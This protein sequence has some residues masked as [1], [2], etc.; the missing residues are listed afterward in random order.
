MTDKSEP[1]KRPEPDA[2]FE[3]RVSLITLGVTDLKRARAFY[4]DGLGWQ[5]VFEHDDIIFFQLN[6]ILLGLF[7]RK[8]LLKDAGLLADPAVTGTTTDNASGAK[9][10]G[11][12]ADAKPLHTSMALA[13]NTRSRAEV[14]ALLQLAVAAGARQPAPAE[15]KFWGGY[16]G[17]FVDPEGHLWEIA[18][19]PGFGLDAAGN[20]SYG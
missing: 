14:D 11:A 16:S 2:V 8:E 15:E 18:W 6:A 20:I 7:L 1:T 13:Y 4:V 5:P 12:G 10:A 3:A 19:N 17:Y 9:Q